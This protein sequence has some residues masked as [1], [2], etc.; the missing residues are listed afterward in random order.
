MDG[1]DHH[2]INTNLQFDD[3]ADKNDDVVENDDDNDSALQRKGGRPI[4]YNF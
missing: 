4:K 1:V 3:D 2:E